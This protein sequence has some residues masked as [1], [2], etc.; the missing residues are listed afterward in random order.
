MATK[1]ASRVYVFQLR[2][3]EAAFLLGPSSRMSREGTVADPPW[4]S[5]GRCDRR[6]GSCGVISLGWKGGPCPKGAVVLC[7]QSWGSLFWWLIQKT[8]QGSGQ[9][10]LRYLR[11]LPSSERAHVQPGPHGGGVT[12]KSS[13]PEFGCSRTKFLTEFLDP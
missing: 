1:I 11:K 9:R 10:E 2:H 4:D 3:L 8:G 13:P 5:E 12:R 7:R 6:G